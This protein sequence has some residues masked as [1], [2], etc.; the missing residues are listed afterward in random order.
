[1]GEDI[2][3]GAQQEELAPAS[4][5]DAGAAESQQTTAGT[6]SATGGT[7]G[8]YRSAGPAG[9]GSYEV[10]QGECVDSIA[11]QHGHFWQ[12]LWNHPENAELKRLRKDPN[13]LMAGDRLT[14]PP[15]RL[16]EVDGACEE[17]H[18]FRRKGV[19]AMF[20]LRVLRTD[21]QPRAGERY[22]LDIDGE[23][24]DGALDDQGW[25]E[26]SIPPDAKH[27]RLTVEADAYNLLLGHIDPIEEVT[28][29]QARLNNLGFD[30]GPLDGVLGPR[31]TAALLNFQ[32]VHGL[33][34]TGQ[35]DPATREK[36]VQ[37]HGS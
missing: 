33:E 2:D 12:T 34:R 30:C 21:G 4:A 11:F 35:P 14:V 13:V 16:K 29:I 31:S 8:R 15:I 7:V 36:L 22:V 10:Q 20:R 17:R 1:M 6:T 37:E 23:L 24:T 19:P 25:L 18:S 9:S 26:V 28:G 32:R 3:I 27:G 5:T